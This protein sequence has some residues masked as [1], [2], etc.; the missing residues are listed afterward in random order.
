METQLVLSSGSSEQT[1]YWGKL[2]GV[3][4]E[5]GD[6]VALIGELGTG[7]TTLAQGIAEGLGVSKECYVTSPTFTIINEY[8]GRV[9]VY[10]LDFYRIESPSEIENLG[11]EEY[12]LGE[13]VAIIEWA[14]KIEKF[15]SREYL[16]I[17]LEYV[18]YSVRKMSMRGIGRRYGEIIKAVEMKIY[19]TAGKEFNHRKHNSTMIEEW[20]LGS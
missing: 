14:E 9:P 18:E 4:L 3:L 17:M 11:L 20:F 7:K 5:G 1:L 12:F 19:K 8:K 2:L 6:V 15:L 13:G 10:H 16:M